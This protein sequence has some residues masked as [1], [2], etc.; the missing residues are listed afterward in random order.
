[1]VISIRT[2]RRQEIL[3]AALHTLQKRGMTATT[4]EGVAKELKTPKSLIHYHFQSKQ[5][6]IFLTLR[7][8]HAQRRRSIV[9]KLKTARSPSERLWSIV[10]VNLSPAYVNPDWS[11][12]WI[13]FTAKSLD[14]QELAV[15]QKVIRRR[16]RSNLLHALR[17]ITSED[18]AVDSVQA[19]MALIEACR[20]WT[21]YIPG[22][23]SENAIAMVK[24]YLLRNVPGFDPA[25]A[26][27]VKQ[28]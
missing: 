7:Y 9:E 1:V 11:N 3:Q 6:L 24:D 14:E 19:I 8:A 16:E 10:S 23:A 21:G 12:V 2:I 25:A 22:Y 17:Q 15:L 28:Q 20:L 4:I 26:T 18:I 27:G 5:E 13:S